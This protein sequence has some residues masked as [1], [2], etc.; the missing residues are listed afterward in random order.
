MTIVLSAIGS[1]ILLLLGIIGFFL[2]TLHSDLKNVIRECAAN[3]AKINLVDQKYDNAIKLTNETTQ[4]EL[5]NLT[6]NV[7]NL[8]TSVD[9]FIRAFTYKDGN[10]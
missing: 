1:L 8:A 3:T 6:N 7:N 9:R 2:K 10:D 5:K 4:L